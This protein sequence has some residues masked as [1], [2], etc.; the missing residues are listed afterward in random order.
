MALKLEYNSEHNTL[1][2]I[3]R[4]PAGT[5]SRVVKVMSYNP[6]LKCHQ[7]IVG[8]QVLV[9]G[10][11]LNAE[12]SQ[13]A[14]DAVLSS[15]ITNVQTE[16]KQETPEATQESPEIS[17]EGENLEEVVIG[18]F[19]KHSG[20]GIGRIYAYDFKE[21]VVRVRFFSPE[22]THQV[23]YRP[24]DRFVM[25]K[26]TTC[27][28]DDGDCTIIER[29]KTSDDGP[30]IYKVEY[31]NGLIGELSENEI[32][33][34]SFT[35]PN[36]P[37]ELLVSLQHEGYPIFS[38]REKLAQR[39]NE[40][41]RKGAG[42]RSLLS[43][44]I[45]LHPHQAYVAGTVILDS[46]QRYILADEVGLGKTIE[47][48]IIIH[49][50]LLRNPNAKILVVCPGTLLQQWFSEMYSK[51][52]GVIFR[53][54]ELNGDAVLT[55]KEWQQIILSFH[56]ALIH[57]EDLVSKDWDLIV[58]DEVHHLLHMPA[59]YELVK[60]LSQQKSGLLL[61]SALPAQHRDQEY[62]NLLSL[63]EPE[64]YKLDDSVAKEHFSELFERQRDI[65]GRIGVIKRR[66]KDLKEGAKESIPRIIKQ[67]EMLL[68]FPVLKDDQ[69]LREFI[70]GLDPTGESFVEGV[71][72]ILHHISDF[73]RINRRI[74]RNRR[75]RLFETE[76]LERIRRDRNIAYYD[77]DQY[78]IDAIT[79]IERLVQSMQNT[80]L[81]E[82]ILLPI[83]KQL[84]HSAVHPK[85]LLQT[86][87]ISMNSKS[88]TS[89]KDGYEQLCDMLSYSEWEDQMKYFWSK[90]GK[91]LDLKLL[92]EATSSAELWEKHGNSENVRIHKL[93]SLLKAKYKDS[94]QDKFI[95]F[96]GYPGLASIVADQLAEK[97]GTSS[98]ARFYH[99][100]HE[101]PNQERAFKEKEVKRFK[102]NRETWLLISD[103]TGG[104]GRN[105]QFAAELIHYDLP[106][107]I[108]R[109]EQRIGRLDRL[110]RERTEVVSNL[111][112]SKGSKEDAWAGCLSEGLEI[113]TQ[114][115]SGLEF[116][117]R[118]IEMEVARNLID[119]D[120]SLWDMSAAIKVRVEEERFLDES[121]NQMDEASY[122]RIRAEAFRRVQSSK[123]Q[124]Q[125]LASDFVW[126]FNLISHNEGVRKVKGGGYPDDIIQFQPESTRELKLDF[127][128]KKNLRTG[129]FVRELAQNNPNL[130]FFSM[131]NDFFDSVCQ[132]LVTETIG[133]TYAIESINDRW[134]T[135][136]GFE[137]SY[138]LEV[139]QL[140]NNDSE[141]QN[142]LDHLFAERI[143]HC[144]VDENNNIAEMHNDLLTFR[145]SF[146][147]INKGRTWS[148]L[149]KQKVNCLSSYYPNW[150]ERL[151]T[152]EKTANRYIRDQYSKILEVKVN[153]KIASIN[154]EIRILQNA[155]P[156]NWENQ[157]ESLSRLKDTLTSWEIELDTVGFLSINGGIIDY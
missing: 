46:K 156:G 50:L 103:E 93:V 127:P 157:V 17:T 130:E 112:I 91:Y 75:E 51:F 70:E 89:Q 38:A 145:Q 105:F 54:P 121:R 73:Y 21:K 126:Y 104:E 113:F 11:K 67:L 149:T 106:W 119:D 81:G 26:G 7:G 139:K 19:I 128:N 100:L 142:V 36:H 37:L 79:A 95:L 147:K 29:M 111:I 148:N 48:G 69:V 108:S 101:D 62:Y 87:L 66:L 23:E 74:L 82:N 63:L 49:D 131:G 76:Q 154:E 116:A 102:V 28:A 83:T 133:R 27:S 30:Y 110:G 124:D 153:A 135:W 123:E 22:S 118:N 1:D 32:T 151:R 122:E 99:G 97:F 68:E 6:A 90:A 152:A 13:D 8:D 3:G 9:L 18:G 15:A 129:T 125:K 137:F 92:Q 35:K 44:R 16:T 88:T 143:E 58:I 24:I 98:I 45:D 96:A 14:L 86:L 12:I 40:M 84:F 34:I 144:F 72:E 117:L 57:K 60:E 5:K 71:H 33:P 77:P 120:Q 53:L 80:G 55:E 150:E 114:S 155:R 56:A 132:S 42:V 25:P 85:T 10:K 138:R 115:I 140:P 47:A 107:Q 4:L 78:E 136:R 59:L 64:H 61:L 65:G 39:L 146:N 52:S 94:P 43:S 134:T 41:K 109:I 31:D 20:L 141:Y 2:L